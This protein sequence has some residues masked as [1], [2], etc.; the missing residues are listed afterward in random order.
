MATGKY[1]VRNKQGNIT[2]EPNLL[3][4][5][6]E[7]TSSL[8]KWYCGVQNTLNFKS[9]QLDLLLQCT[10]SIGVSFNSSKTNL[11]GGFNA[12]TS[13]GNQ[14]IAALD[15]WQKQVMLQHFVH[16]LHCVITW[17]QM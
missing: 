10:Q 14:P 13:V 15:R 16:T 6:Y 1:T 3:E 2:D 9:F 8:P 11:P 4:D 7:W 12:F 5:S 17:F